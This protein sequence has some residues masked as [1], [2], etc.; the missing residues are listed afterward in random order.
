MQRARKKLMAEPS[1][2]ERYIAHARQTDGYDT[3][4]LGAVKTLKIGSWVYLRDTRSYSIFIQ[5]DSSVAFGVLGLTDRIRD[6]VGG[7]G[8]FFEAGVIEINSHYVCDG[9]IAGVVLLGK[10]YMQSYTKTLATLRQ[11]G[12]F[13]THDS[14]SVQSANAK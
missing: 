6:I 14:Q 11:Q 4:M 12:H 2:M 13:H 1:L 7:S 8:K 9:L 3:N 5:A 10:G